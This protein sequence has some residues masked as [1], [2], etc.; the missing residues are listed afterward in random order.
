M[1]TKKNIIV[2]IVFTFLLLGAGCYSVYAEAGS[3]LEELRS[4]KTRIE[5]MEATISSFFV[6]AKESNQREVIKSALNE[7]LVKIK[8]IEERVDNK[9][10]EKEEEKRLKIIE[11]TDDWKEL[12]EAFLEEPTMDNFG[13]FCERAKDVDGPET[14]TKEILSED[15]EEIETITVNKTLYESLPRCR[16]YFLDPEKRSYIFVESSED[17]KMELL[18]S[19]TDEERKQK[20]RYNEQIEE[21][22]KNYEFYAFPYIQSIETNPASHFEYCLDEEQRRN[23]YRDFICK[24]FFKRHILIPEKDVLELVKKEQRRD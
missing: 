10:K 8:S 13:I 21:V 1:N 20:I 4:Q 7:L 2:I 23:T 15:R 3:K 12:T 5:Q 18:K 6:L 11:T 19:D 16:L 22:I 24:D 17:H 9:I 14:E